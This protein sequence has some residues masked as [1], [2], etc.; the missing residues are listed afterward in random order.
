[1]LRSNAPTSIA[2][3]PSIP[4][5][6][7]WLNYAWRSRTSMENLLGLKH[8][9]IDT[10]RY[11][12]LIKHEH[13]ASVDVSYHLHRARMKLGSPPLSPQPSTSPKKVA[14]N[15]EGSPPKKPGRKPGQKPGQKAN[16]PTVVVKKPKTNRPLKL[17]RNTIQNP[18]GFRFMLASPAKQGPSLINAP[19]VIPP[20][21]LASV[22]EACQS[23]SELSPDET[24]DVIIKVCKYWSLKRQARS[25]AALLKRLHLEVFLLNDSPHGMNRHRTRNAKL[26]RQRRM[27]CY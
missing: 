11:F 13:A 25:G 26:R 7:E 24:A 10:L 4:P 19:P 5:A 22:T 1:V 27:R 9:A 21:M 18:R 8:T 20:D 15:G 17:R 14:R 23:A 3:R 16:G 2:L 12:K 6:H